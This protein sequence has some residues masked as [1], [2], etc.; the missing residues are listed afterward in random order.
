MLI[1]LGTLPGFDSSASVDPGLQLVLLQQQAATGAFGRSDAAAN[2]KGHAVPA[3]P[4]AGSGPSSHSGP[5]GLSAPTA[6]SNQRMTMKVNDH[7]L[8]LLETLLM[9]QLCNISYIGAWNSCCICSYN[10]EVGL[11]GANL[12]NGVAFDGNCSYELAVYV[13]LALCFLVF[14]VMMK[15]LFYPHWMGI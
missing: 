14:K 12:P 10:I 9:A 4:T 5:S 3:K 13:E 1:A 7:K 6:M 8:T 11:K 15:A 2:E